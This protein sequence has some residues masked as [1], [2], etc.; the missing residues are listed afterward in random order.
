ME[1]GAHVPCAKIFEDRAA[2]GSFEPLKVKVH[3]QIADLSRLTG[4]R[5]PIILLN[6]A[7]SVAM[8]DYTF[9]AE[10]LSS[11]GYV[12]VAI[13]HDLQADDAGPL[14][15]EGS[16][17]SRNAKVIDNILYVFE[18]L[19]L[20]QTTLFIGKIDLKRIGLIG[21]SLGANSLLLW[22]NRTLNS[23]YKDTRP[24]L[25]S[26][27]DQEG[28]KE[29]M[30]LMETTR[31]SYPLNDRYPLF[32]LLAE[33]RETYQRKTGCYDQITGSGHKVRYYKGSTHISFM[34]HGFISPPILINP[35][36]PYF[37]GTLEERKAFF[38]EIRRDIRDFLKYHLG[39]TPNFSS[40]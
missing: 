22:A 13:Q 32:F 24:A 31:F 25:L 39:L 34:D 35:D 26:R 37:N 18:W 15:W 9:I 16:S 28:V 6:H 40:H 38:D 3:S 8:T 19:K 7:S 21:H 29:C 30:I 14:F 17:F 12:V 2:I 33:E 36:E 11:H 4:D 10:D 1:K 5:N 23:F 20:T 27:I